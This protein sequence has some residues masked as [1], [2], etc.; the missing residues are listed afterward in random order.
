MGGLPAR[1][2]E[3][4]GSEGES[5]STANDQKNGEVPVITKRSS[6]RSDLRA[7]SGRRTRL[8]ARGFL[9]PVFRWRS[10]F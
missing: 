10:S 7:K 8:Q 9:V 3:C 1:S 4:A 5:V 6:G 2:E